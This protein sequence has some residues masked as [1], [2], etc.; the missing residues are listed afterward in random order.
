MSLARTMN[1]K[2]LV[3]RGAIIAPLADWIPVIEE[4]LAAG[5]QVE[6]YPRGHSMLPLI[7]EGR[8]SVVLATL[9][10]LP[11]KNDVVLCRYGQHYV[12]HRVV[13]M[14]RDGRFVLCGD[15]RKTCEQGISPE[16]V[17]A[18]VV[19]IKREGRAMPL[20]SLRYRAYV[21]LIHIRRRCYSLAF[22]VRKR[23]SR[24]LK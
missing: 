3:Q 1:K 16:N 15:N 13:A 7:R 2:P 6:I 17:L 5:Q 10:R 11:Q 8:D 24:I 19:S 20:N 21:A 14:R 18:V 9:C 23:I 22:R 4:R 12:L